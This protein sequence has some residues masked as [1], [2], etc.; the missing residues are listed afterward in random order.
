MD[1]PINMS[2]FPPLKWD[3]DFWSGE[4]PS[5]LLPSWAG[6]GGSLESYGL[7]VHS[8]G[9]SLPTAEQAAAFRHLMENEASFTE[10]VARALLNHYPE[11]REEYYDGYDGA[12]PEEEL[13]EVADV[14]GLQ[15]LVGLTGVHILSAS[16]DGTA[17]VGF[18]LSC[19]WDA[20]HGAGV[21][22][23]RRRVVAAGQASESFTDGVARKDAAQSC[24]DVF[25][26][27]DRE[28][29][30]GR[31]E[32]AQPLRL[33]AESLLDVCRLADLQIVPWNCE[34]LEITGAPG[35]A[36]SGQSPCIGISF[37]DASPVFFIDLSSA[38][39]EREDY[40]FAQGIEEACFVVAE[41][42]PRLRA[43]LSEGDAD[44]TRR[45]T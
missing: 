26:F 7:T 42:L 31:S 4:V 9:K 11:A 27:L 20:E 38:G 33:L 30:E 36:V 15:P 39:G 17:Y 5:A 32:A 43:L 22:T 35:G 3:G 16:R 45:F 19:K 37:Q 41:F 24:L 10:A 44:R 34:G 1:E 28:I 18:E 13:P 21:L 12:D 23:H 25:G 40:C 14:A 29:A 6:F 2:P 8:E